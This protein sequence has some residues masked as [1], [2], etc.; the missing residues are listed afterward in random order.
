MNR[1]LQEFL[2]DFVTVYLDDVIIFTKGTFKQHMNYLWQVFEALKTT[3]LKIKLKKCHFCLPNIYFLGYIVRRNGIKPDPEKIKKVKNYP[4]PTNLTELHAALGL[5][6][7]YHKFIKDFS[8]IA[9]PM[10]ALLKKDISYVWTEKQQTAFDQL[11]QM[12][13]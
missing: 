3:N 13:V 10:N 5:F 8:R 2:G 9:R 11:R 7:Y 1:I 6:S 4:I 12:L